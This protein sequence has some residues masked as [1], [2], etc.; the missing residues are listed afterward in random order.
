[1]PHGWGW[2]GFSGLSV[3]EG[4]VLVE[5]S[6]ALNPNGNAPINHKRETMMLGRAKKW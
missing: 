1:M 2:W 5:V 6:R 3:G 4:M